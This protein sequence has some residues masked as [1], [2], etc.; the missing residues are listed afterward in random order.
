MFL[1][2]ITLIL[3]ILSNPVANA[4]QKK[5]VQF[6]SATVSNF[7]TYALMSLCVIP[8][9]LKVGW[10]NLSLSVYTNA[11]FAGL[12]C[13]TGTACLIKALQSGDLSVLGPINSYKCVIGLFMA[14]FLLGEI[15]TILG[16]FGMILIIFGSWFVFDATDE[17]FSLKLFKR[18]DIQL[19]FLALLLTGIEAAFLKKVIILLFS[20]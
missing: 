7:Y 5:I 8:F 6:N 14:F 1:T 18:R 12:L 2:Y 10:T 13:S 4:F 20:L 17:G 19:R 11:F 15:P 3:R 16:F 9:A